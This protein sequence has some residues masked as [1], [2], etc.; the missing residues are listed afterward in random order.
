MFSLKRS[1]NINISLLAKHFLKTKLKIP[2]FLSKLAILNGIYIRQKDSYLSFA[3]IPRG[4][5]NLVEFWVFS[6]QRVSYTHPLSVFKVA[7]SH[8]WFEI[9]KF[10]QPY[11]ADFCKWISSLKVRSN[12][13]IL[14]TIGLTV[15]HG[16]LLIEPYRL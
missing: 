12:F 1:Q 4:L 8:P 10:K 6:R 9:E 3:Y 13:P 15:N 11:E 16:F 14:Q 5:C 2:F 7:V